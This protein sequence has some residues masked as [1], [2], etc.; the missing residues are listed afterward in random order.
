MTTPQVSQVSITSWLMAT[1][2]C[3]CPDRFAKKPYGDIGLRRS[4]GQ[5]ATNRRRSKAT[6]LEPSPIR[7]DG[8]SNGVGRILAYRASGPTVSRSSR[9]PRFDCLH[10]QSARASG[11]REEDPA[12]FPQEPDT[13]CVDTTRTGSLKE[14]RRDWEALRSV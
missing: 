12:A 11:K 13:R 10:E 14:G 1:L 5:S 4:V 3:L 8:A 9:H 6:F 7:F 2:P